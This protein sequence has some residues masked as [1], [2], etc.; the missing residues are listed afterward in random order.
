[1]SASREE[2]LQPTRLM[3]RAGKLG[4]VIPLGLFLVLSSNVVA[5]FLPFLEIDMIFYGKSEYMLP[6]SVKLMWLSKL[7]WVAILIVVFSIIFPLLKTLSLIVI[8]FLRLNP[9]T[10][11]RGIRVLEA[12]GKWSMLDIFVVILLMV[13]SNDQIFLSTVPKIGLQ[14]FIF[15]II[16]NMIMSRIVEMIDSRLHPEVHLVSDQTKAVMPLN[17]T[18]WAGWFVPLLLVIAII[19]IVLAANVPFL[20]INDAALHSNSYSIMHAASALWEG[21]HYILGVF[22]VLFVVA[23]PTIRILVIGWT[24]FTLRT[25]AAHVKRFDLIRIIGEWSMMSVF[26]LALVMI[27]T[28]GSK[29]VKTQVKP[30]L[31]AIVISLAV[32]LACIWL[33]RWVLRRRYQKLATE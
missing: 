1:M 24:W 17:S 9:H 28:E 23:L 19:S 27:M 20:R 7:Y 29:M 22:L 31:F 26:L 5:L 6:E 14:F 4:W 18:G 32:C 11:S 30:G 33:S 8:W 16:G 15:A 13:L 2:P 21:N 3:T 10:R 12:L 25:K